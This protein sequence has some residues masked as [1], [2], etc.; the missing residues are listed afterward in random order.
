M[1]SLRE[2]QR[3]F[4]RSLLHPG[5]GTAQPGMRIYAGNV[6]GNWTKALG[7]AYPILRQLVGA[8]FFE[9]L[10]RA[11]A[12]AHPSRSSDLNEFGEHVPSFVAQHATT[13]DLPY[14]PDVARMEWFAHC[15]HF[16]AD[17]PRFDVSR[18]A[19]LAPDQYAVLPL[20]LA[21]GGQ[22]LRSPWPLARIWEIHQD[23]Y[24]GGVSVDLAPSPGQILVFRPAW[25][26]TVVALAP[27]DH[28]FLAAAQRGAAL[29]A[30]L[31]AAAAAD[32]QFDPAGALARWVGAGAVTL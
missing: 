2:C 3:A 21:P 9:A 32:A 28:Q 18:L 30:A 17:R 25:K 4:G 27:G 19:S 24:D 20:R 26:A 1:R 29:G 8:P 31:E 14:L 6:F 15:A 11:Y 12:R 7:S 10:A 16:A 23:G 13:Q 22:L 5:D